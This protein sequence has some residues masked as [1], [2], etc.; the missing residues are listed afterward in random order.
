VLTGFKAGIG[1]VI[2]LDPLPKLLGVHITKAGFFRDA[3]HVLQQAPHASLLTVAVAVATFVI[4]VGIERLRPHS[5]APLV[6]MGVAIAATRFLGL[7]ARGVSIVGQI[8]RGL[9]PSPCLTSRSS[10]RWCPGPSAS[11]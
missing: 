8:P 9:P 3:L 10:G 11:R 2:V 5:A 4:L 7:D 6:A 1:L